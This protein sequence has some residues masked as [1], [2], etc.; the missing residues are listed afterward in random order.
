M[1]ARLRQYRFDWKLSVLAAVLL[2]LLLSLGL[3]Q[4]DREAEKQ[5]L[6]QTYAARQQL[7]PVALETLNPREDL[8]YRQVEVRGRY[9]NQHVFLLDN[10]VYQGRVG[11]EVIAPLQS[12]GGLTVLINRGWTPAGPS[13]AELPQVAAVDGP[14]TVRG[15]VYV[16]VGADFVLG[17]ELAGEGWPRVVQTLVP[18]TLWQMAGYDS[19]TALFPYT[20][21]VDEG[22][23]GAL[24]RYWPVITTSPEKHR[25]Y[26]VQW[27]AM[28]AMLLG[29]YLWYSTRA[30][31]TA[32]TTHT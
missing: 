5:R 25:A 15:A 31:E 7:Q 17:T 4:L 18:E 8:Q 24:Q 14:V 1:L 9:D 11:Y 19:G 23:A 30:E 21:R 27:F 6:Q 16:P 13:R 20:V 29:L 28:A 12:D 22:V 3:W 26:A 10:R 2:P 32:D